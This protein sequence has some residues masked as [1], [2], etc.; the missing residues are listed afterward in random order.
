MNVAGKILQ[1]EQ[2]LIEAVN[3]ELKNIAQWNISDIGL[4][5]RHEFGLS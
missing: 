3:D 1:K 2:V 4:L 5:I